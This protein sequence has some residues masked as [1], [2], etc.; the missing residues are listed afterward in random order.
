MLKKHVFKA[1][2]TKKYRKW[3]IFSKISSILL[4]KAKDILGGRKKSNYVMRRYSYEESSAL[5]FFL[6]RVILEIEGEDICSIG[7]GFGF[8]C[9]R[10]R[11]KALSEAWERAV[12]KYWFL[13]N[14]GKNSD[15]FYFCYLID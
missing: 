3:P 15:I 4:P 6:T 12:L 10:A 8:S 2:L 7:H 5:P 1:F 13:A 14:L 9:L 11:A